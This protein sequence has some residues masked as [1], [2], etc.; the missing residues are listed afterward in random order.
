MIISRPVNVAAN[1]II[2]LFV[3]VEWYSIDYIFHIF[4]IHSSVDGFHVWAFVNSAAMNV[5]VHVSFQVRVF[6]F[7]R[8]TPR[9]GI[10]ESYGNSTFSFLRNFYTIVHR[11]YTNLQTHQH[12]RR[13]PFSPHHLQHSLFVDFLTDGHFNRYEMVLHCIFDLHFSNN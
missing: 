3:T 2:S 7:S 9:S 6:V 1:D 10:A 8:Y 13:V 11:G 12:H 5:G 4:S